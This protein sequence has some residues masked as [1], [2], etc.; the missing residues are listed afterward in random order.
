[1]SSSDD[2]MRISKQGSDFYGIVSRVIQEFKRR[3]SVFSE[4]TKEWNIKIKSPYLP[5][6][7]FGFESLEVIAIYR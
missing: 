3:R 4:S 2:L 7:L 1:M 6:S 5:S